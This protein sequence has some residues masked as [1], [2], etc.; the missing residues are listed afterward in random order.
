MHFFKHLITCAISGSRNRSY[1]LSWYAPFVLLLVL[2]MNLV[3]RA[4]GGSK[5]SST[6]ASPRSSAGSKTPA[7]SP[8]ATPEKKKPGKSPKPAAKATVTVNKNV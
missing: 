8:K 6:A 5:S 7:R 2:N 1:Y 3:Y 4:K